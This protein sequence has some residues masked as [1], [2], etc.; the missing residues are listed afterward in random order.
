MS[1]TDKE[2]KL[3]EHIYLSFKECLLGNLFLSIMFAAVITV[4]LPVDLLIHA[5]TFLVLG[6]CLYIGLVSHDLN[7]LRKSLNIV[8]RHERQSKKIIQN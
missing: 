4:L 8:L 1:E 2:R 6:L 5:L 3:K 7:K